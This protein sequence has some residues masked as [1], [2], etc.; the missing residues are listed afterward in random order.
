M[1]FD[2]FSLVRLTPIFLSYFSVYF[3]A[4]AQSRMDYTI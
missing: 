1:K 2:H 3:I 4:A